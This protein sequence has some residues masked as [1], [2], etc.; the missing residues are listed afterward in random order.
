MALRSILANDSVL[1]WEGA[2]EVEHAAGWS[3]GWRLP[4][5]RLHLFPGEGLRGHARA[6]AGVRITFGT[7]ATVLSGRSLSADGIGPIDLVVHER[8]VDARL[9]V[10]ETLIEASVASD[11]SFHF[12]DLPAGEKIVELWLPHGGD[13]RLVELAVDESARTWAALVARSLGMDLT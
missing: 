1:T 10:N 13:F 4:H 9:V 6:Q 3:R 7:D 8:L 2:I 5:S 12:A 11:G